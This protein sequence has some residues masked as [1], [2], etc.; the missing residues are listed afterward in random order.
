MKQVLGAGLLVIT[1]IL[2]GLI[3]RY[4]DA[5]VE[6]MVIRY[7]RWTSVVEC[8]AADGWRPLPQYRNI[9]HMKTVRARMWENDRNDKLVEA[10]RLNAVLGGGHGEP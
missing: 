3:F 6:N 1:I 9:D 2:I 10:I 4:E 7:D 8:L 5:Y